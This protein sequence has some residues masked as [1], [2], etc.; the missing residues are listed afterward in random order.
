MAASAAAPA[1]AVTATATAASVGVAP[2]LTAAVPAASAAAPPARVPGGGGAGLGGAI[3]N[4]AGS[5][6]ITN[7]TLYGNTAQGGATSDAGSFNAGAA[8]GGA[9]FNLNG[10]LTLTSATLAGNT[11]EAAAQVGSTLYGATAGSDLYTLGAGGVFLTGSG[12]ATVGSSGGAV[13]VIYN[14]LLASGTAASDFVNN[15]SAVSGSGNL[16]T[17]SGGLALGMTATTAQALAL[18]TLGNNGGPTPTIALGTGSAAIG[19]GDTAAAANLTTDQRGRAAQPQQHGGRRRYEYQPVSYFDVTSTGDAAGAVTGGLGTQVDPFLAT[20]LRTAITAANA[21]FATNVITFDPNLT[22]S[23]SATI[24]LGT[25]GDGTAGP[26]DFG[27]YDTITIEGT[28]GTTSGVTLEGTGGTRLFYVGTTGDLTIDSLTLSGGLA[29]GGQ[30]GDRAGGAAGLGGAIFNQGVLDVVQSTLSGN[31]AQG[32]AGGYIG[33]IASGGGGLG[34]N[35]YSAYINGGAGGGPNGGTG[36]AQGGN[37]GFGGGG[38][39]GF[40]RP[41][42]TAASAAAA[43]NPT[44]GRPGDGGFGGGTAD[45]LFDGSGT[46]GFGAG[47][48]SYNSG[49]GGGAGMG[50]AIFNAA[51]SVTITNSTLAGNA[52]QGGGGVGNSGDGSGFGGAIFNLNGSL[53]LQSS[54]IAGNTVTAGTTGTGGLAAGGALYTLG[55]NDVFVTGTGTADGT[56]P[57]IGSAA[58]AVVSIYNTLL[59]DSNGGKD[60][61]NNNSTVTGS[62]N[63]VTQITGL[64]P[65]MNLT[66]VASFELGSLG[67]NGGP[68]ETIALGTGNVAINAGDYAAASGLTTDQRGTGFARTIGTTVDVG[69]YEAQLPRPALPRSSSITTTARYAHRAGRCAQRHRRDIHGAGQCRDRSA[70]LRGLRADGRRGRHTVRRFH[71]QQRRY[72]PDHRHTPGPP[73]EYL[74]HHARQRPQCARVLACQRHQR[75]G[76][77]RYRG[78]H[79]QCRGVRFDVH[80]R[81]PCQHRGRRFRR[82]GSDDRDEWRRHHAHRPGQCEPP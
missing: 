7:S 42:A 41:P 15:N 16:V 48:G 6:T 39:W 71:T 43:G 46:P 69:A 20:T 61:V 26:S 67:S 19:Q 56:G 55:L 30:G 28:T 82:L 50:G 49:G 74:R 59:V 44:G 13:V 35:G 54:T 45:Y 62:G 40:R 77:R 2:A 75:G 68:T 80:Q 63:F 29:Q 65:G 31:T 57:T 34:G 66:A 22:A 4:A 81:L 5:V 33:N 52:A 58:G 32:G 79:R 8:F 76:Q 47:A 37:G 38:G 1:T 25:V 10:S 72:G 70:Q 18:G 64:A 14:T 73:G 17:Q 9:I 51:G 78:E 3:F 53:T 36:C 23:G 60:F 12:G 27:I 24:V 21:D 11:V